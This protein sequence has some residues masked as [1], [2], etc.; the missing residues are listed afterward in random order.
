MFVYGITVGGLLQADNAYELVRAQFGVDEADYR[1]ACEQREVLVIWQPNRDGELFFDDEYQDLSTAFAALSRQGLQ[2]TVYRQRFGNQWKEVANYSER[3]K[4]GRKMWREERLRVEA[5]GESLQAFLA[6]ESTSEDMEVLRP[7]FPKTM[8]ECLKGG[9]EGVLKGAEILLEVFP[10]LKRGDSGR[11]LYAM[12]LL[13]E[14]RNSK[15]KS[16]SGCAWVSVYF[17]MATIEMV[18]G[19]AWLTNRFDWHGLL[20]APAAFVV[21]LVPVLGSV[22]SYQGATEVWGWDSWTAL[23]VFF[24]YYLPIIFVIGVLAFAM[25]K[26]STKLA[27]NR[28]LGRSND[29]E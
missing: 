13:N 12:Q 22:F 23:L 20:A 26:G 16:R 8:G 17:L 27:W 10:S 28:I 11:I 18:A 1:K 5:A 19:Y 24:W 4:K 25:S 2:F 15:W 14:R 29:K 9:D 21:G 3:L 6:K 7:L